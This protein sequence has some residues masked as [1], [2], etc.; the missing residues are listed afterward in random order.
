M[1]DG[2]ILSSKLHIYNTI[3]NL[4][5]CPILFNM[6]VIY[7]ISLY[8]RASVQKSRPYAIFIFRNGITSRW[9]LQGQIFLIGDS[10]A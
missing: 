8:Y 10:N 2:T 1:S 9:S 7:T 4:A 5:N 3:S 6:H